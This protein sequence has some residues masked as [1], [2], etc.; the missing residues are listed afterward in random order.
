MDK[1]P[2]LEINESPSLDKSSSQNS[3][4]NIKIIKNSLKILKHPL[5]M[6]ET[7]ILLVLNFEF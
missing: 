6:S 2:I 5:R 7:T 4:N 1:N 3:K